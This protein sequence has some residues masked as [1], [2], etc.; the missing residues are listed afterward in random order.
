MLTAG[1]LAERLFLTPTAIRRHL[2][3]LI[4][5]G[6]VVVSEDRPYG[7]TPPRGRG[8]PAGFY[9]LTATGRDVFESSYDDVAVAALRFVS[10]RFGD[11]AVMSFA[12]D[13][14]AELVARYTDVARGA[15]AAARVELLAAHLSDDGYAASATG[16]ALGLQL[17]Q[18]HCPVAHVAEEF[19]QLCEAEREAFAQ[20]LGVHVTRLATI[21]AGDGVCTALVPGHGLPSD[22]PSRT[23][24]P[25]TR[26][27]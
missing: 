13:R 26:G 5:R 4:E 15:S 9:T 11:D 10:D 21:A 17:C 16:G 23:V 7:P 25:P 14:A 19:P 2:E 27:T 22:T 3:A 24:A 1:E 12:R 6:Y 8:R 20:L 18:H